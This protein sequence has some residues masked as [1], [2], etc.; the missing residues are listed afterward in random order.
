ME[1]AREI[2]ERHALH[3]PHATLNC[4]WGRAAKRKSEVEGIGCLN[5]PCERDALALALDAAA[6]LIEG[7]QPTRLPA[8]MELL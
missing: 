4:P 6:A 1:A 8:S 5:K 3:S 7:R 2:W